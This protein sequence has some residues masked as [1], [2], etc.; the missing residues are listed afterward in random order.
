MLTPFASRQVVRD[1]AKQH[2]TRIIPF[3][4]VDPDAPDVVKQ[5]EEL[6]AMVLVTGL[7]RNTRA[8]EKGL[9]RR[10]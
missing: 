8:T 1:A 3:G 10:I 7:V 6:H 4:F 5:V 2:P 9:V